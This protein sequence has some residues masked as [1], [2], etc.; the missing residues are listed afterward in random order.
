MFLDIQVLYNV[1]QKSWKSAGY[2]ECHDMRRQLYLSEETSTIN[3]S[4]LS[5]SISDVSREHHC[6][7]QDAAFFV[8]HVKTILENLTY[9]LASVFRISAYLCAI[10][11]DVWKADEPSSM[12]FRKTPKTITL[13]PLV[14]WN[15]SIQIWSCLQ[16]SAGHLGGTGR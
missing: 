14:L 4:L 13:S 11:S 8:M 3:R 16:A 12:D 1:C 5:F 9:W 6:N 2:S 10:C 15:V 7:C